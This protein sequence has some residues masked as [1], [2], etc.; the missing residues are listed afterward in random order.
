MRFEGKL[1]PTATETIFALYRSRDLERQTEQGGPFARGVYHW[2]LTSGAQ[3]MIIPGLV[4][5]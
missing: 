1:S 2:E 5:N 3:S 4:P